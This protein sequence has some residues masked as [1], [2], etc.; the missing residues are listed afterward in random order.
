MKMIRAIIR[1]EKDAGVTEPMK[2]FIDDTTL[3]DGEQAA[4]VAFTLEEKLRIARM[5]DELGVDQIE[6]GTPAMGGEEQE[7]VRAIAASGLKAEVLAWCRATKSDIDAA[8]AC[9][10][11]GVNISL[12]VSDIHIQLKLRKDRA[13]VLAQLEWALSYAKDHDLYVSVGAEDASRADWAFLIQYGQ[14]ASDHGADRLR[15]CDTVGILDP[16][17][18]CEAVRALKAQFPIPLE[19]HTHNDFGLATANALAAVKG[20]AT[21]VNA[22]VN[23]LGERAGN[24]ALEEVVM[25]LTH[26]YGVPLPTK[27]SALLSLCQEVARA[28]GRPIPTWKAIVGRNVFAH[29]SGIHADGVLK[30]PLTYEAFPPE[31]IGLSRALVVGKH[32]GSHLLKERFAELGIPLSNREVGEILPAIRRLAVQKK[33]P[34]MNE[35]LVEIYGA[36]ISTK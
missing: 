19:I 27:R 28:S 14:T 21:Y 18:T 33:R 36:G 26:L 23:G 2:V 16:F 29:E 7:A 12:P 17:T 24:A 6:A 3:R 10:V 22:T 35:E 9:Q 4:G 34:L 13:W 8:L 15:Y 20:G 11:K 30:S 25:A 31:E 5:L 32:T 1:P